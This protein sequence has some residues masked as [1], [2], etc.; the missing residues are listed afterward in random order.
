MSL[1]LSIFVTTTASLSGLNSFLPLVSREP[2]GNGRCP[3]ALAWHEP[4]TLGKP[5]E[6]SGS[7]REPIILRRRGRRVA[8]LPAVIPRPASMFDQTAIW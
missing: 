2:S 5:G 8:R 7:E 4:E 6:E 1:R 3:L